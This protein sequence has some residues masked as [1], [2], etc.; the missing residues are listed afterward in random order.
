MLMAAALA[1]V[2]SRDR[3]MRYIWGEP[4]EWTIG[5]YTSP[6]AK[7]VLFHYRKC[8]YCE[9]S[10]PSDTL[11]R[12]FRGSPVCRQCFRGRS[13][14]YQ[15]ELRQK[16]D[17]DEALKKQVREEGVARALC[18]LGKRKTA[19][20]SECDPNW[21]E[22]AELHEITNARQRAK[23]REERSDAE[24]YAFER[25]LV[26]LRRWREGTR[27]ERTT[28]AELLLSPCMLCLG[29]VVDTSSKLHLL[30]LLDDRL[31]ATRA[32]VF[33]LC[34]KCRLKKHKPKA[35]Q[36]GVLLRRDPPTIV[37]PDPRAGSD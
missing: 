24:R 25:A 37:L 27:L 26:Y 9:L 2:A 36:W 8:Q 34:N 14:V 5:W 28:I 3:E 29:S 31:P 10:L 23:R 32:N 1:Q 30:V 33:I 22:A 7:E 20:E 18:N 16:R 15:M 13:V 6:W 35:M 21:E 4:H 17:E 11:V 12:V 19:P